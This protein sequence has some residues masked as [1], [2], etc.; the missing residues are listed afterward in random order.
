M[1]N[2][3]VLL[4]LTLIASTLFAQKKN[5][6]VFNEHETIDKTRA[7]WDAVKSGDTDK[8][9]TFFAD[10]VTIVRN[11]NDWKTT[12]ETFSGNTSWWTENFVDFDIEDSPGAYPDAIEYKEGNMWVQDWLLLTGTHEKTGI[13]LDLHMHCLY[14]FDEDGKIAAF[15]QYYNNNV[16][17]NIR[18]AQTT[19][20]NG[21]VYINHPHI[22]TV[23]KLLNTYAA[24][25]VE[26]LKTFFTENATFSSLAGGWDKSQNLEERAADVAN[27]FASRKDIHFEQIGY[28]DCIFYELNSGY[29]VY[30][31][32]NYSY[33]DE[34]SGKKVTMPLMLSHSF[35]D[36]GKIIQEMAY[37]S[38][39]H[40]ED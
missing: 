38:T 23:R 40:V 13:N 6:T 3:A 39:N 20:E 12:A 2:F 7:F 32:W 37:F 29:V 16:F 25:D 33:T 17:E 34:E 27:H 14:A 5:G 31:W 35:N 22:A 4:I 19:K 8:V 24:E 26:S 10:S 1:K 18:D 15:I 36:D 11:G 9:K 28:P 30:S 21:E